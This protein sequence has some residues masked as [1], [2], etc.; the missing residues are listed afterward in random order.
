ME[1]Y[2]GVLVQENKIALKF[3][4]DNMYKDMLTLPKV[5]PLEENF[6]GS[7]KHAYTKYRLDVN[8]YKIEE[9]DGEIVWI[10][11]EEFDSAPISSLTK[12]AK[13]FF[14]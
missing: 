7:F 3:S 10:D 14:E 11:L 9:I 6:L 1:L 5:D 13:K 12:K 4:D 8:I 2:F